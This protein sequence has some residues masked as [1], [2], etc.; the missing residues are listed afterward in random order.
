MG[1]F[2]AASETKRILLLTHPKLKSL[3]QDMDLSLAY[4]VFGLAILE[5]GVKGERRRI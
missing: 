1:S 2:F 5:G 3:Y 4:L